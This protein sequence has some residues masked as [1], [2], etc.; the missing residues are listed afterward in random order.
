MLAT[1]RFLTVLPG[2]MLKVQSGPASAAQGAAGRL[3]GLYNAP[4]PIGLITLKGRTLTPLAQM[5]IDA[6][7]AIAR[8]MAK[9]T[10]GRT[11]GR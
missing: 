11:A 4:M 8:P 6:A 10:A 5:V 7:R 1:G 3:A 9:I 2:F